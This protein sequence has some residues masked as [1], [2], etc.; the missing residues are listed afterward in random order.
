M[1]RQNSRPHPRLVPQLGQFLLYSGLLLLATACGR[2]P[3]LDLGE[4]A[5]YAHAYE[6]DAT[7]NGHP[8]KIE[9]LVIKYQSVDNPQEQGFCRLATDATPQIGINKAA[10]DLMTENQKIIL[11]YHELGHCVGH[12]NVYRKHLSS[13]LSDGSPSSLMYPYALDATTFTT[14]E[15]YYKSELYTGQ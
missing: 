5:S 8:V 10:W 11:M 15:S 9:D 2:K 4:F 7:S 1:H 6:S 3:E 14:A 12:D 13:T